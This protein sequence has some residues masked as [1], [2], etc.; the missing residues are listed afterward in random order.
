MPWERAEENFYA[1]VRGGLGADLTWVT[2]NGEETTDREAL[3]D[4]LFAYAVDGLEARGVPSP[5][6]AAYVHP[7]RERVEAGSTPADWKRSGVRHRLDEGDGFAEAVDGTQE[8][9][10]RRQRETLLEGTVAEWLD[11]P[12]HRA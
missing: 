12:G 2:A 5:E 10:V 4:D 6:A 3:Y 7:L 1:A 11:D 9:Y 8:A